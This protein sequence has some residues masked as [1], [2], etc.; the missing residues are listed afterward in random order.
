MCEHRVLSFSFFI[1][2]FFCI[3]HA[4]F[5]LHGAEKAYVTDTL[6]VSLRSEPSLSAQR[7]KLIHSNQHVEVLGQEGEFVHVRTDDGIEG[8]LQKQYLDSALPK[9]LQLK[10]S[11]QTVQQLKKEIALLETKIGELE[12]NHAR[13]TAPLHESEVVQ[14][15]EKQLLALQETNKQLADELAGQ[16][17][18][19]ILLM[20][21]KVQEQ[22]GADS[23]NPERAELYREQQSGR[24]QWFLA[25]CFVFFFGWLVGRMSGA[26][27]SHKKNLSF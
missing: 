18:K 2:M 5:V 7:I 26:G 15:Y 23:I 8:W 21:K 20:E 17:K 1:F 6:H 12:K 24:I 27:R 11:E 25:G 13:S 16:K 22:K 19:N 14:G 4:P 10:K 3:F 9:A